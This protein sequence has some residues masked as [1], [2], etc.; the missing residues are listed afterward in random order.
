MAE[1]WSRFSAAAPWI[2][3]CAARNA[4]R[5]TPSAR[6]GRAQRYPRARRQS[7][8]RALKQHFILERIAEE[9]KIEDLPEDY[10][11]E[12]SL[13]AQQSGETPRRV[14]ARIEKQGLMDTLRN[15]IIES[16]VLDLILSHA[17]FKDVAYKPEAVESEA[18]DRA[19]GGGDA[20]E[21]PEAQHDEGT[22]PEQPQQRRG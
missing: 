21:I 5:R 15:Q 8:A 14:R 13:I 12:I 9:E 19:A 6:Q 22:S 7:T 18:I 3:P 11:Q 16:K 20:E 17:K 10:D 4:R 2:T 1:I